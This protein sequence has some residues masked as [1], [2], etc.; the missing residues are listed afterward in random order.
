MKVILT[1]GSIVLPLAM[2]YMQY[3]WYRAR[4]IFNILMVISVILFGDISALSIWQIIKDHAVF[5]T[6][7]HAIFLDPIFLATGAYI[8]IYT[9]Y[10]LMLLSKNE[11]GKANDR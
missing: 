6:A 5:M 7:I 10:R 2:F 11:W 3:R 4:A 9:I 1:I 8:G